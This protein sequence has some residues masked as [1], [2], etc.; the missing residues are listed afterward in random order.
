[1]H[2]RSMADGEARR[3]R[4][5]R[6]VMRRGPALVQSWASTPHASLS[7]ERVR[8]ATWPPPL[9]FTAAITRSRW[10]REGGVR[11][12]CVLDGSAAACS[13]KGQYL[14]SPGLL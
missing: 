5:R 3:V 11:A 14:A 7:A 12:V 6:V 9:R 8:V 2:L 4:D 1:M 10:V 13:I